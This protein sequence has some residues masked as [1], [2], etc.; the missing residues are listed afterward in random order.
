M[1][2]LILLQSPLHIT[3]LT[4]NLRTLYINHAVQHLNE[5]VELGDLSDSILFEAI[6]TLLRVY[7]ALQ[8]RE[9]IQAHLY[10]HSIV[11]SCLAFKIKGMLEII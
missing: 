9:I 3:I 8:P 6:R 10:T 1:S 5:S 11:I 4:M 7:V 2:L